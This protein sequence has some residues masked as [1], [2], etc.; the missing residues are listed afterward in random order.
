MI[1]K[2]FKRLKSRKIAVRRHSQVDWSSVSKATCPHECK[3]DWHGWR[4]VRKMSTWKNKAGKIT[5]YNLLLPDLTVAKNGDYCP[6]VVITL[7][8]KE[9]TIR[10]R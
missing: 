1:G 2:A 9:V 4:P 3:T 10:K 6:S 5:H 8:S 7:H